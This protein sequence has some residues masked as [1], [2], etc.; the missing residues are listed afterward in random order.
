MQVKKEQYLISL[1]TLTVEMVHRLRAERD[2]DRVTVYAGQ[3]VTVN[4]QQEYTPRRRIFALLLDTLYDEQK[5]IE[6]ELRK[7]D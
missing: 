6:A 2:S 5:R 3:F 4:G 7:E 1:H